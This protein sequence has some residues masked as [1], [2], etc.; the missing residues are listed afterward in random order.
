[1]QLAV[2]SIM[3]TIAGPPP[4]AADWQTF[5]ERG[6]PLPPTQAWTSKLTHSELTP[7]GLRIVDPSAE[8]GSGRFYRLAWQVQPEEGAVV[9][10]RL[11]AIAC[12]SAWGVSLLAA[13]GLHEQG[14]TFY[15]DR[16]VLEGSG[17]SAPFDCGGAFHTYT[18]HIRGRD[19]HLEADGQPLIDGTGKFVNPAIE[20]RNRLGFGAGASAA[21]GEAVWQYVRFR[22]PR[23]AAH[24]P[25]VPEVAGLDVEI[26]P[27]QVILTGRNYVSMFKL[28][29]G[30]IIVGPKRSADGG[31]T[32]QTTPAFSTAAYQFPD[33]EIIEL[34]FH[35]SP[36]GQEGVFQAPLSRSRDNGETIRKETALLHIPEGTGGTGDDGKAYGGPLYDH[37]TVALP[38]GSLLAAMYGYFKSDTVLV[39][40][41]PAEWKLYKYRTFVVRSEDRGRT[42]HY[43][44]TVAYDPAVGLESFCEADLLVLA[45]GR[46][47]CF[48]RTGG[49]GGR[50][51]PLYLARSAD[52]GQS[53]TTPEPIADRGV[54]PNACMMSNGVIACTYG[55]PDNWLTFSLDQGKTWTGHFCFHR[56]NSSSYN[57]VEEVAPDTLLVVYDRQQP[58]AHGNAEP[59]VVGT[60]LTV[61]RK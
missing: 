50:H 6:F 20:G 33:G 40:T 39:E 15:P 9:E 19:V 28:A 47:L 8:S 14:I 10:A 55:R 36:T 42:W 31:K 58:N 4:A 29:D 18:I 12:S 2:L 56:G 24:Q 52:A 44:A 7:D 26:G 60:Y 41:F 48:L 3:L 46:I 53:W 49:S 37:A 32:W 27:T 13:D 25:D 43:L 21:T 1:M 23:V 17:L 51:T 54:W 22:G 57:S 45:D 34:G 61:R 5:Y 16:I 59:E 38:D 30:R 11:K 35:T